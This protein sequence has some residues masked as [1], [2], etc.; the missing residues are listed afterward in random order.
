M[1]ALLHP[2]SLVQC[3]TPRLIYNL[4]LQ[5]DSRVQSFHR[6]RPVAACAQC[7]QSHGH[8]GDQQHGDNGLGKPVIKGAVDELSKAIDGVGHGHDGMQDLEESGFGF[9]G[10]EAAAG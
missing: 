5:L 8:G 9:H 7:R 6:P 3:S 4:T 1:D 10:V 2:N